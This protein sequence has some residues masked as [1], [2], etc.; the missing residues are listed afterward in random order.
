MLCAIGWQGKGYSPEFTENMNA[1][2]S[3]R[4]R[5][6]PATEVVFTFQ[7][8][9]ICGACPQRRGVSCVVAGRIAGLDGRHAEVL[10]L[11]DG[12][13]MTWAEAQ[14]RV[15]ERIIPNDLQRICAGCRWLDLGMCTAAVSRLLDE[16]GA[17]K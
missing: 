13:R 15:V 11:S 16:A 4:L 2:V 9:D 8:D 10:G 1:V 14:R 7:A 17:A 3:G 6:D 12:L 5:A